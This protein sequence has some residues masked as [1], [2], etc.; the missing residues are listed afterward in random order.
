[1]DFLPDGIKKQIISAACEVLLRKGPGQFTLAEIART[2]KVSK[3]RLGYHFK[4]ADEILIEVTKTWVISG[5]QATAHHLS[6]LAGA[7]PAE[8]IIGVMEASFV[9]HQKY[10]QLAQLSALFV[11]LAQSHPFV[12]HIQ[13]QAM[14]E[15]RTRI[16]SILRRSPEHKTLSSKKRKDLTKGI[17]SLMIGGFIYQ[18][19]TNFK[20]DSAPLIKSLRVSI[21]QLI[22]SARD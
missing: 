18:L 11:H 15:S 3:P 5:Q 9:W 2:A 20:D 12:A 14:L 19:G 13:T 17:H 4:T 7:S 22:D 10:P 16:E 21:Q 6:S 1:M 8:L